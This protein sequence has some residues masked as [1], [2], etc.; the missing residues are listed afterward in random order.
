MWMCEPAQI[1]GAPGCGCALKKNHVVSQRE[2]R[3][4]AAKERKKE[5][6]KEGDKERER[7]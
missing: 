7:M 4:G 2:S 6:K 5:I 1:L 3:G